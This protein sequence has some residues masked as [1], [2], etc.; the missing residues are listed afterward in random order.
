MPYRP[1]PVD[2]S[3]VVKIQAHELPMHF[4]PEEGDYD[5]RFAHDKDTLEHHD[6]ITLSKRLTTLMP[7]REDDILSRL[8]NFRVAYLNLDTGEIGS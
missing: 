5:L 4:E 6:I 1:K 3:R 2:P 8:Q 7:G